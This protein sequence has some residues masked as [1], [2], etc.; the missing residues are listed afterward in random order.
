MDT[1]HFEVLAVMADPMDL[2]GFGEDA[3]LMI[4]T[5]CVVLPAS[6]PEAVLDIHELLGDVVSGVVRHLL[7]TTR[8]LGAAV[9]V[10]G[11]DIPPD[12]PI[13]Q[14]VERRHPPCE[15]QG[16]LMRKIDRDGEGKVLSNLR[17]RRDDQQRIIG[18]NLHRLSQRGVRAAAVDVVHAHHVSQE[19][20]VE[21]SP[22]EQARKLDPVIQA[23]VLRR[24]V[25]RVAPKALGLM[26]HAVHREGVES[27]F[28]GHVS[29]WAFANV[30]LIDQYWSTVQN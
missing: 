15:R 3:S 19:Q 27:K 28:A 8:A 17:H 16:R 22:F 20:T 25:A 12:P 30:R 21:L 10:A 4:A 14:M 23:P 2:A 9:Q 29:S 11:H 24:P 5:N 18:R 1:I 6:F 26:P 13:G 7:A